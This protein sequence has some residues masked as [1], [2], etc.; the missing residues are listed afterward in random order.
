MTSRYDIPRHHGGCCELI[1]RRRPC[2]VYANVRVLCVCVC[3]RRFLSRSKAGLREV[4]VQLETAK[5]EWSCQMR[6]LRAN[7]VLT[8][9]RYT[10]PTDRVQTSSSWVGSVPTPPQRDQA[11]V[12]V[13]R[14]RCYS[15]V[16][17]MLSQ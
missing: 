13:T 14:G 10:V 15:E 12:N 8:C 17:S 16:P 1:S 7:Q 9:D 6:S 3:M 5:R 4:Q 2:D 11:C